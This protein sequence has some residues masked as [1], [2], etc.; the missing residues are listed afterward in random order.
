MNQ[1]DRSVVEARVLSL[2]GLSKTK[3]RAV[4]MCE[5]EILT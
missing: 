4:F 3:I 5:P 1:A 2:P